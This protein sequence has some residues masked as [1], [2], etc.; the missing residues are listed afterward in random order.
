MQ[1]TKNRV[2]IINLPSAADDDEN[3]HRVDPMHDA[4]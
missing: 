2:V 3:R 4:Q 1:E